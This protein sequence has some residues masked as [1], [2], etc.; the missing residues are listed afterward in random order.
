MCNRVTLGYF[1]QLLI[2]INDLQSVPNPVSPFLYRER[3]SEEHIG[4]LCNIFCQ[5]SWWLWV[6]IYIIF[7]VKI[8]RDWIYILLSKS[9]VTVNIYFIVKVSGDCE[10]I[11]YF[12]VT[13]WW[14]WILID[15]FINWLL[16]LSPANHNDYLRTG[17]WIYI[18]NCQT[19]LV[20][21]NIYFI[22]KHSVTVKKVGR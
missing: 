1:T 12:I 4:Y 22:A 21:V 10:Y 7:F 15:W 2:T 8:S 17:L 11:R 14:L 20:T 6:W 3:E 13:L 19:S 16:C 18:L 5:T 9:L